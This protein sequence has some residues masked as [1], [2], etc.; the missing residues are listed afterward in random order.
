MKQF[1]KYS[2]SILRIEKLFPYKIQVLFFFMLLYCPI[3]AQ[4]LIRSIPEKISTRF[5]DYEIIGKNDLG[6]VVHFFG[7]NESELV[8]YSDKLKIL[9]RKETPIKGRGVSLE[10]FILLKNKILAF[11]TTNSEERQYFKLKVLDADLNVSKETILLDS[12]STASLGSGKT[13]YVKASP[14]KS[15]L[16]AFSILK[17]RAVYFVKFLILNDS[18]QIIHQN[19]FTIQE[20]AYAALKSMKITNEGDVL[21][22]IG[23]ENGAAKNE[24]QYDKYTTLIF[25]HTSN[26]IIE[27]ELVAQDYVFKHS[28]SELSVQKNL[29]FI[30]SCYKSKKD[31]NDIGIWLQILNLNTNT[32]VLNSKMPYTK[33]LLQKSQT[34]ETRTWQEKAELIRPKRII[35]RSDGGMILITEGEYKNTKIDRIAIN[36]YGYYNATNFAP[37]VRYIDQNYFY[38][39]GIFSFSSDGKLD[40][41]SQIPKLQSSENDEGYY[42]SFALFEANNVL[43]FLFNEDF[44]SIGNFLEYNVNPNGLVKRL[45][46][47]NSEKQNLVLAPLK[48]K[49]LDGKSIVFP[50]EQKRNLQLVIFEY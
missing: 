30:A 31:K 26:S 33:E 34:T 3:S 36:N 22:V 11:Y 48:A 19:I 23:Q 28:I 44:Y 41:Q 24:Y 13:F 50:S 9:N 45:S 5:S 27:Q 42:S 25:N 38:D 14:D 39:I 47:M 12:V 37:S 7:T 40:W 46:V 4:K 35:P 21:A 8:T 2:N 15:K 32:V 49:Q 20:G 1:M 43:K 18:L 10:N 6:L 29:A 16:L 17:N